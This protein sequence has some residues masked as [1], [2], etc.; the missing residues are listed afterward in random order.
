MMQDVWE[1]ASITK[2]ISLSK[3]QVQCSAVQYV[4]CQWKTVDKTLV[5][6]TW[7]SLEEAAGDQDLQ[8]EDWNCCIIMLIN[9]C[10]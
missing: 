6:N 2:F 4:N 7:I 9:Y 5:R 10:H 3:I 8:S 1:L